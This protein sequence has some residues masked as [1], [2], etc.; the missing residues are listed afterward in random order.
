MLWI[1]EYDGSEK[2]LQQAWDGGSGWST[3]GEEGTF[4]GR[5]SVYSDKDKT[6]RKAS[7]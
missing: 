6:W 3:V 7:G 4:I 5:L 1:V 2:G